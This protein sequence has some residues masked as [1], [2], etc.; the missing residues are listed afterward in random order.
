MTNYIGK[1]CTCGIDYE[2]SS[3]SELAANNQFCTADCEQQYFDSG[4]D[5]SLWSE[6]RKKNKVKNRSHMT[7]EQQ[8]ERIKETVD[9]L[10]DLMSTATYHNPVFYDELMDL[11]RWIDSQLE[12]MRV[13]RLASDL[14]AMFLR[15]EDMLNSEAG[16]NEQFEDVKSAVEMLTANTQDLIDSNNINAVELGIESGV[17]SAEQPS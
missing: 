3:N 1:C 8:L 9:R 14:N 2:Y 10:E 4:N 15:M 5:E 7:N 11:Q 13:S 12:V 6:Q 16:E 17:P